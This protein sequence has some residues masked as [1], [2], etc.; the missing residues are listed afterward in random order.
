MIII[1]KPTEP[2]EVMCYKCKEIFE[3][4]PES[5]FD[6]PYLVDCKLHKKQEDKANAQQ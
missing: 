1:N 6:A 4:N 5:D 3:I 2:I